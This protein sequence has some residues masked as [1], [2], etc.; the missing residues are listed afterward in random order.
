VINKKAFLSRKIFS[1][2]IEKV[3]TRDGYGRGLVKAGEKDRNVVVLSADLTESTRGHWFKKK[4]PGRFVELGVAEQNL[5][6]VA[7][8]M[9]AVGKIPFISSYAVFSPGRNNEQIRT[10]IAYNSWGSKKGKEIN[11]KIGGAHAG[12]SVGPDGATHQALEDISLMRVQPG[13]AV[14]VPCDVHECEKATIASAARPGPVY[15]RFGRASYPVI[16]TKNTPFKIGRAEVFHEGNDCAII[17][18]GPLVYEALLAAKQLDDRISCRVINCHTIKP[19]DEK[20]ILKAAKECRAIVTAEEHMCCGG[21][22]S[23][24]AEFVSSIN[25]VPIL[26]IGVQDTFGESG[27]PEELLKKFKLTSKDISDAVKKAVK[28]KG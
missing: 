2:N 14:V 27:E 12:V 5:A 6:S 28:M 21:L 17:A 13:M 16:T 22:G 24:I 1:K 4:F 3:K 20:T 26:R 23:T 18:C 19:L 11:V 10:T 25:P 8:G 9:A 15:L 7:S